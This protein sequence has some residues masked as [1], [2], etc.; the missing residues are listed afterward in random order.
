[1]VLA[2]G[3]WGGIGK[4]R[5]AGLTRSSAIPL[6]NTRRGIEPG[7]MGIGCLPATSN[8]RE[9]NSFVAQHG[10]DSVLLF[11]IEP[12][13]KLRVASTREKVEPRPAGR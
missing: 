8:R 4:A 1:V 12:R 9:L 5:M 11:G 6:R 10:A 7:L 13:G 2:N 3:D